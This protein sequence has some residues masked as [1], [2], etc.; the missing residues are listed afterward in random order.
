MK[1]MADISA[2]AHAK[3]VSMALPND[4]PVHI[5]CVEQGIVTGYL[6]ALEDMTPI[7]KLAA[8]AQP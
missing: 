6:Q 3:A 8:R 5:A 2:W 7:V 1:T 4:T